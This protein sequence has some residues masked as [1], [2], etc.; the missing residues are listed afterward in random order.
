MMDD[1]WN[2]IR[3]I[4]HWVVT[5]KFFSLENYPLYGN[6]QKAIP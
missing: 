4:Y 2:L 5:L 6:Q 1:P 3:E